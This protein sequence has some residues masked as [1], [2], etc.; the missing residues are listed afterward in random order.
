MGLSCCLQL[1]E[2]DF[3][4]RNLRSTELQFTE[5]VL[6]LQAYVISSCGATLLDHTEEGKRIL[7]EKPFAQPLLPHGKLCHWPAALGSL[8]LLITFG[9]IQKGLS[10]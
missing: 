8:L 4:K 3:S 5:A 9:S 2:K 6:L 1:E 7:E 10:R